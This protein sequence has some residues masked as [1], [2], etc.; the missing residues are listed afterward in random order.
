MRVLITALWLLAVGSLQAHAQITVKDYRATLTLN[1]ETKVS[2]MKLYI[3]G[4]GEGLLWANSEETRRKTPLYCMP[5][6]LELVTDNYVAL[7]DG[8]IKKLSQRGGATKAELDD[9][10]VGVLL[11]NGLEAT[12]PCKAAR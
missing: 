10:A 6:K 2:V 8:Q 4:I 7:I 12:F 11:L 5:E 1:D 3:S 9:F